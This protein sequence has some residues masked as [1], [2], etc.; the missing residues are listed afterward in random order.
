MLIAAMNMELCK[1]LGM[2]L[3][4]AACCTAQGDVDKIAGIYANALVDL[5]QSKNVLETVHADVDSLQV[6]ETPSAAC[7]H[8]S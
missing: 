8:H 3:L 1:L 6:S 2:R 7:I 4:C 5:A